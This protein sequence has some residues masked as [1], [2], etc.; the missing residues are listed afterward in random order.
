MTLSV[1][2][3]YAGVGGSLVGWTRAGYRVA[4]AHETDELARRDL[5]RN[6][7]ELRLSPPAGG[8]VDLLRQIFKGKG[9]DELDADEVLDA[10]GVKAGKLDVLEGAPPAVLELAGEAGVSEVDDDADD[11]Q[12]APQGSGEWTGELFA[13]FGRL[14]GDIRPRSF[15]V[16][17]D[18]ALGRA[19][20]R[21]YLRDARDTLAAPVSS[22]GAAVPYRVTVREVE[23]SW[24]GVPHSRRLLVFVGVRSDLEVDP[25]FPSPVSTPTTVAD[26]LPWVVRFRGD[27]WRTDRPAPRLSAV[28]VRGAADSDVERTTGPGGRKWRFTP[29]S[30]A[31]LRRLAGFPDDF[32]LSGD[33]ARQRRVLVSAVPPAVSYHVGRALEGVL[34]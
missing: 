21:G 6:F 1:A 12:D 33:V 13:D 10:A 11:A 8:N 15:V 27:R 20:A 32:V 4:Y 23:T 24:L 19:K 34:R 14:L 7:P 30:A 2:S 29:V 16:S 3:L 31:E 25:P 5:F 17:G 26:V 22:S 18:P 28:G 9:L